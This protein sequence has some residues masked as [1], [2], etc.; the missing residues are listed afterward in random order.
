MATLVLVF[1]SFMLTS[2]PFHNDNFQVKGAKGAQ[3]TVT[4]YFTK[5]DYLIC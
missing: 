3:V 4:V 1:G 5:Y 2:Q